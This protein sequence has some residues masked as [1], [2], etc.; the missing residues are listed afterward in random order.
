MNY[1]ELESRLVQ[2]LALEHRP[3]AVTFVDTPPAEV[4]AFSGQVPA[5]C[6]FWQLASAGRSFYTQQSDH[7]NCAVGCHTHNIPLPPE[8]ESELMATVGFMVETGYLKMEEV[9]GISRM[10]K[11]ARQVV[12]SPLGDAK[13][14]PDVVI[15]RG[16][17][18]KLMLLQE[19]GYRSGVK[20]ES[21]LLA[22]PTCMAIPVSMARGVTMST[23]CIGNRVYTQLEDSELYVMVPGA[24]IAQVAEQLDTIVSANA[25]LNDYHQQRRNE[26]LAP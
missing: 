19:A 10:P 8:R 15:V 3:V 21:P 4:P 25:V 5:G 24:D 2:S 22:R 23:G 1:S 20:V 14:A 6:A 12:Y 13:V 18:G 26:L 11:T 17:P 9:P 7:Y 16:A